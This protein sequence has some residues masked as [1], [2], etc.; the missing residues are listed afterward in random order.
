MNLRFLSFV[1]LSH[2]LS[3]VSACADEVSPNFVARDGSALTCSQLAIHC[4]HEDYGPLIRPVCPASCGLCPPA[5]ACQDSEPSG[6]WNREG[7]EWKC[8]ELAKGCSS[9][10]YGALI[11]DKCP[12][13]CGACEDT[14]SSTVATVA[15]TTPLTAECSGST[16]VLQGYDVVAFHDNWRGQP[17]VQ[18]TQGY[19][20]YCASLDG[21]DFYFSSNTN[22][23]RFKEDPWKWAPIWG[24]FCGWGISNE[25]KT[26][27]SSCAGDSECTPG[28]PWT[29]QH[30]EEV[31]G[32]P[33]GTLSNN[34]DGY[35]IYDGKLI[36]FI[37]PDYARNWLRMAEN[38]KARADNRWLEWF[39]SQQ[40]G[41]FNTG[42]YSKYV[43]DQGN[44]SDGFANCMC[45][46]GAENERSGL[47]L[48][49]RM[50]KLQ[51]AGAGPPAFGR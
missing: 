26:I 35:I 29:A 39:G 28:W 36:M 25:W 3:Q 24:G 42:C 46:E 48:T 43:G 33:A 8:A 41:P 44:G 49:C 23:E 37:W 51:L 30:L 21:Y 45:Y 47:G 18:G 6:L 14:A 20:A 13:T 10:K 17:G 40:A 11:T 2:Q 31:G 50:H 16:P 1:A 32:P 5:P 19:Q 7:V 34:M 15:S 22:L 27:P 9:S 38:R 12:Q 4:L